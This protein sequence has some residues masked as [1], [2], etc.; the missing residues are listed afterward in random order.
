[1]KFVG[2]MPQLKLEVGDVIECVNEYGET[3][4]YIVIRTSDMDGLWGYGLVDVEK[5]SQLPQIFDD[6]EEVIEDFVRCKY[7]IIESSSLELREV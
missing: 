5:S 7:R 3:L 6:I 1:M 2:K 4:R